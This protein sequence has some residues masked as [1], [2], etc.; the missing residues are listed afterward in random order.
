VT[1]ASNPH[2]LYSY[3]V[4]IGRVNL[5]ITIYRGRWLV[6]ITWDWELKSTSGNPAHAVGIQIGPVWLSISWKAMT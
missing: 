2:I 3:V 1:V 4:I 5:W 6:G